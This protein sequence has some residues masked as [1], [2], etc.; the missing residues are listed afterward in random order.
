MIPALNRRELMG[1]SGRALLGGLLAVH[2]SRVGYAADGSERTIKE[3]VGQLDAI[4]QQLALRKIS[5]LQWQ[6]AVDSL[7]AKVPMR[8]L[9]ELIDFRKL[10]DRM[11]ALDLAERGEIFEDIAVGPIGKT[12]S[13]AD[14]TSAIVKVAHIKKGR[15][16]PPHGHG[17]M[18]S[19]FL[20]VS[21]AFDVRQYDRLG[22][23][24]EE[25]IVRQTADDKDAGPGTWSSISDYRNNVHWLTAKS[26]DCFL[27]TCKLI[28]LEPDR[29][30]RGRENINLIAA[31]EIGRNT[32][33]APIITGKEAAALY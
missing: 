33:R 26:D 8:S 28:R 21:G 14:A 29:E 15:S 5:A 30:F 24:G 32:W 10:A 9:L 17:N 18:T 7:F 19:A 20:C 16:I 11:T 23:L 1:L 4:S 22:D 13:E 2:A 27:F 31:K 3:W 6:E 25:M 12:T